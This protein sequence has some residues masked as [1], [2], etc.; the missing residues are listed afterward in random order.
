MISIKPGINICLIII[1]LLDCACKDLVNINGYGNCKKA[2][3]NYGNKK[4][5]YVTLP[6]SCE[7][8]IASTT[9]PGEKVSAQACLGT[10]NAI[11]ESYKPILGL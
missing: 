7:D 10:C 3:K 11:Y 9:N 4:T 8:L 1:Y 2:D 5:C 6:S